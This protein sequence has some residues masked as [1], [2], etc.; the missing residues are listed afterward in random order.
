MKKVM[1]LVLFY[2]FVAFCNILAWG[3]AL[4]ILKG[5]PHGYSSIVKVGVGIIASI[6][7]VASV[8][9]G[10]FMWKTKP[11]DSTHKEVK[12]DGH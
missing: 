5:D 10:Y 11:Q 2:I 3:S 7:S 4:D 12:T 8:V 1:V 9:V 6:F